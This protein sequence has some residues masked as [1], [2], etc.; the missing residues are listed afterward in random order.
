MKFISFVIV[1][2][3]FSVYTTAQNESEKAIK[4][5]PQANFKIGSQQPAVGGQ[6][7][8][9][10]GLLLDNKYQVGIGGGYCT[11][12]GMGGETYPLYVDGRYY[13]SLSK[14]LLF[15]SKDESNDFL[16]E[17]Q[18]G[19]NINNNTP[20]KTGFIATI[21]L[22]YR[23][24]F[25]HINQQKFLS[26]YTGFNLEYSHTRF[27][28]EYGGYSIKDGHLNHLILNLKVAFDINPIKI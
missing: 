22:A 16:V 25:I 19:M 20:Y 13:F 28:D 23:F 10:I 2:I 21:G 12:M 11:N 24:D 7:D 14:N 9:V 5:I 8:L 17:S 1:L 6:F 4:I 18:I 27:K 15:A 26:F 3:A